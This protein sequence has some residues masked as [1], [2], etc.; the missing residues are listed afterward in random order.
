MSAYN[1]LP[2]GV[3]DLHAIVAAAVE[4]AVARAVASVPDLARLKLLRIRDAAELLGIS[5]AGV[6]RLAAAGDLEFLTVGRQKRVT[7]T[8]I[9]SFIARQRAATAVAARRGRIK[10]LV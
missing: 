7:V 9:E 1:N 5:P 4:E 2:P 6:Y 10:R 8:S 3:V